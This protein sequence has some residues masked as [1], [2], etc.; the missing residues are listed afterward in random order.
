MGLL[1][2]LKKESQEAVEKQEQEENT[3][4]QRQVEFQRKIQPVMRFI[5]RLRRSI[6]AIFLQLGTVVTWQTRT[7][8]AIS[9]E[10]MRY[11]VCLSRLS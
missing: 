11:S 5:W 2:E 6:N 3:I 8:S 10:S 4:R 1:D 9:V 7:S